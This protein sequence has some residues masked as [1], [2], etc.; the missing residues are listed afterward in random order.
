MRHCVQKGVSC[1]MEIYLYPYKPLPHCL[2]PQRHRVGCHAIPP[3][4]KRRFNEQAAQWC[5]EIDS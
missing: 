4:A 3:L 2:C 5:V 1:G